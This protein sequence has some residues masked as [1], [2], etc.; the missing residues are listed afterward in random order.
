MKGLI[1]YGGGLFGY[2]QAAILSKVAKD[3]LSKFDFFAGTSVGAIHSCAIAQGL[4]FD[5]V[6]PFFQGPNAKIIFPR[7][8]RSHIPFYAPRFPDAGLNTYLKA[9]FNTKFKELRGLVLIATV[10]LSTG[11][12]KV[13]C[14]QDFDDGNWPTWE[15]ARMAV[16]AETYFVPWKG[17]GDAGIM[18]NSPTMVG[19]AGAV[20]RTGVA[21]QD[22]ELL[23]I[24]T[25]TTATNVGNISSHNQGWWALHI[26][27]FLM[28]GATTGMHEYFAASLP[29]KKDVHISFRRP[30]GHDMSDPAVVP[31]LQK[32]WK[33]KIIAGVK[34][35]EEF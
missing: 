20:R 29:L 22:L 15:I 24:D 10:D 27:N 7:T 16:A 31:L 4:N 13:F 35:V 26:L 19:V 3:T 25:G 32:A 23:S 11:K 30:D 34:T 17:H 28:G 1:C 2:G 21:L 12:F 6:L 5:D 8:W 9:I 14:N 18:A 33:D